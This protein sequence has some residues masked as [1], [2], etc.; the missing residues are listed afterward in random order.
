MFI[1]ML[2]WLYWNPN[3]VVFTIPILG[4]PVAWYGLWFMLGFLLG[5]FMLIPLFQ[6]VLDSAKRNN[7]RMHAHLLVDRLTWFVVA[8][9][10][11]G[12]RLGHVFLYDWPRYQ[13]NPLS[14]L[15]IWEGG[16]ASHG[17]ALGVMLALFFYKKFILEKKYPEF[18]LLKLMDLIVIPTALVGCFIRIGNFFNQEIVG[19]PSK[20]PWAIIFE[21]PFEGEAGIPRHPTQLYEAFAYLLVFIGI[22]RIWQKTNLKQYPGMITGLF[23]TTVFSARFVIEY[24]K[25]PQSLVINESWLQA[26]QLLSIPFIIL[27]IALIINA[28]L[29]KQSTLPYRS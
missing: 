9:T 12:A 27:G 24:Y 1:K 14:I 20:M 5:Y 22:V 10:V 15:K 13:H 11:I 6:A 17:G 3:P 8:G 19:T 26:G 2:A 21:N 4:R 23:F 16:L 25:T 7:S 18:T 28:S 29:K